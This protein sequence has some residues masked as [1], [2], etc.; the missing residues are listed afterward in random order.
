MVLWAQVPRA[1]RFQRS[2]F[3]KRDAS[4]KEGEISP[5][6]QVGDLQMSKRD[7]SFVK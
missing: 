3:S 6:G 2:I 5:Q 4:L 1:T 7:K